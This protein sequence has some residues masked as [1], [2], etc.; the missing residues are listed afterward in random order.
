MNKSSTALAKS[1]EA[2]RTIREV[3][4][5]MNVEAHVLR[6]WETKFSQ[7]KPMKRGGGRR[8]YR[9][10]DRKLLALIRKWLHEDGYTIRGVQ[11]LLRSGA[12]QV[13]QAGRD[14]ATAFEK[15]SASHDKASAVAEKPAP[16]APGHQLDSGH[17]AELRETLRELKALR[18][19]LAGVAR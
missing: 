2:Y 13:V 18:D 16:K 11:R 8:F 7:V 14:V 5:E 17:K 15:S 12:V 1:P 6:F 9:P 19:L 4:A 10:E 3:A